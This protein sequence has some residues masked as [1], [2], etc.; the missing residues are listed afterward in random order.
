[1][2]S[3]KALVVEHDEQTRQHVDDVMAVLEHRYD[4]AT[5]LAEARQLL[6]SN[7]YRYV[8]L[9]DE[10]PA[11][12]GRPPRRQNADTF[13]EY[14][15]RIQADKRPTVILMV[16]P[17]PTVA[18]IDKMRWSADMRSRGVTEFIEK[19]LPAGGRTPERVIKKLLGGSHTPPDLQPAPDPKPRLATEAPPQ[20]VEES[21]PPDGPSPNTG[22]PQPSVL[23]SAER[24]VLEALSERP[25]ES[26]LLIEIVE[27]GGYSKTTTRRCMEHLQSC[28]YASRPCGPRG[29]YAVTPE[30]L[31][32]LVKARGDVA[33]T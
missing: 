21:T 17:M 29:G 20:A 12:V 15:C 10:L 9:S 27:A 31:A 26:K 24:N 14:W 33:A 30:G 8:L 4:I 7:A 11:R 2:K 6:A 13:M 25:D 28:G 22:D 19:P 1:M 18:D 5:C 23:T 3:S 16:N 32:V